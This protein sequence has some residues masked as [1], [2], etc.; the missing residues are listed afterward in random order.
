MYCFDN[1]QIKTGI[2]SL[3]DPV[4]NPLRKR[5]SPE[6]NP[7]NEEG[8]EMQFEM[9]NIHGAKLVCSRNLSQAGTDKIS[10]R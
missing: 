10:W 2:V 6:V 7:R 5:V 3:F 8:G 4:L 9:Q 1:R